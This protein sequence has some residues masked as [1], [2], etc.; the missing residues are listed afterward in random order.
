MKANRRE[1]R[2]QEDVESG[3]VFSWRGPGGSTRRMMAGVLVASVLFAGA[4]SVLQVRAPLVATPD[5]EAAQVI[6]LQAGDPASDE[7]LDWARFHSP[8]PD[9]WDP[10]GTGLLREELARVELELKASCAYSPRLLPQVV[11]SEQKGLPGLIEVNLYPLGPVRVE[12]VTPLVGAVAK[13]VEAVAV[14][15]GAL[16][17]R[18][19]T[20]RIP[21]QGEGLAELVGVEV[22]FTMGVN[23]DGRVEFCLLLDREGGEVEGALQQWLRRQQLEAD[24]EAPELSYDVV[25]IRFVAVG[26]APQ[27]APETP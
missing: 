2:R 3:L 9:R 15:D 8:F 23:R 18:W 25:V 1:R 27:P 6:V 11:R 24:P 26:S 21:W 13:A 12:G 17:A 22:R 5:R 14:M 19:G 7:L 4:A 20:R 16:G 10:P